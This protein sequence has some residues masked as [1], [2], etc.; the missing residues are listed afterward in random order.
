MTSN[1]PAT[2]A[3]TAKSSEIIGGQM[4]LRHAT[5]VPAF[6]PLGYFCALG[7]LEQHPRD[8]LKNGTGCVGRS[9]LQHK[10]SPTPPPRGK[11]K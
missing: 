11:V 4:R 1:K 9:D 3:L 5:A 8:L 10:K 7:A 2:I 6:S